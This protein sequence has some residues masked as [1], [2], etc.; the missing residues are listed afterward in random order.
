MSRAG[1]HFSFEW[2][3]AVV[4]VAETP[5]LILRHFAAEDFDAI[6]EILAD[7]VGMKFIG[8]GTPNAPEQTRLWLAKWLDNNSYNWSEE[9]LKRVPHL[10]R[11]PQRSA[12]FGMWAT[13]DRATGELIGRCGL[14]AWNL[15]GQLEVEVGYHLARAY[16]GRGLATEAAAAARDYGFDKL[17]FE[18]LISVIGVGNIASERVAIKN[19][20]TRERDTNLNGSPVHIY[21]MSQTDRDAAR[22][23]L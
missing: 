21:S 11:A 18:R 19:G 10:L 4:T 6:A 15:E 7:P 3:D 17:G 13:I 14:L 9:T 8:A 20:M 23:S 22:R 2:G 12:H 16:W 5:R 1:T